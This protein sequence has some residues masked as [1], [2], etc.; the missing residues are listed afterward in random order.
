MVHSATAEC[1][2]SEPLAVDCTTAA[3]LLSISERKLHYLVADGS[4]P[5]I[6]LGRRRLIR[7][8]DLRALLASC[9]VT[10]PAAS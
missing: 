9:E 5:S 4:L 6:K 3:R 1:S 10:H 8:D 2:G 7:M